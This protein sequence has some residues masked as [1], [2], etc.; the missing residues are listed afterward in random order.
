MPYSVTI[1][2]LLYDYSFFFPPDPFHCRRWTGYQCLIPSNLTRFR[3]WT[4]SLF[5]DFRTCSLTHH[6]WNIWHTFSF[7]LCMSSWPS[8]ARSSAS[9]TPQDFNSFPLRSGSS[10]TSNRGDTLDHSGVLDE[11]GREVGPTHGGRHARDGVG[12]GGNWKVS[13]GHLSPDIIL[14]PVHRPEPLPGIYHGHTTRRPRC[15]VR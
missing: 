7:F 1:P 4:S 3:S 13:S 11:P 6:V 15:H 2:R 5:P 9:S 10:Q 8:P 12:F 14:S